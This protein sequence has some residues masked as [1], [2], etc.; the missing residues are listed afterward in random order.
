M[1]RSLRLIIVALCAM[2]AFA[3]APLLAQENDEKSAFIQYVEEQISSENFKISLNGI[4]GTLSSDVSLQSITIADRNGIW[5]TITK[6]R[7]IWSRTSLLVGKLDVE[8]LTAD[9]I[10]FARLPAPDNSAPTAEAEPFSLPQLPVSVLLEQIAIGSV[11][12][13][14]SVFGLASRVSVQ[15]RLALDEELLDVDLRVD[16]QD[17]PGGSLAVIANYDEGRQRLKLLADLQEPENGLFVNLLGIEGRPPVALRANGDGPIADF[18]MQLAFDV[19]QETILSGDLTLA[20]IAAGQQLKARLAGPLAKILPQQHRA[21]F[22]TNSQIGAT[23]VLQDDGIVDI[24][25]FAIKTGNLDLDGRAKLLSDGFLSALQLDLSLLPLQAEKVRLPLASGDTGGNETLMSTLQ[26]NID[27]DAERQGGWTASLAALGIERPDMEVENASLVASGVVAN[28]LDPTSRQISFTAR[29]QLN[30]VSFTDRQASTAFGDSA[31]FQSQGTWQS[32]QPLQLQQFEL[33]AKALNLATTGQ[34]KATTY[35]GTT[36]LNLLDL[37]AFS[38]LAGRE[39]K[40][41]ANLRIE[42]ST[43]FL[44]GAFDLALEGSA[45]ELQL[46]MPT[47]DKLLRSDLVLA[48]NVARN[49]NGI[50]FEA[51]RLGNRQFH[52]SIDGRYASNFSDLALQAKIHDLKAVSDQAGGPLN[53]DLTAN[54][55]GKAHKLLAQIGIESGVLQNRAVRRLVAQ[56]DGKIDDR[57]LSGRLSGSGR[58]DE[59][60]VILDGRMAVNLP[61]GNNALSF[62]VEE[63]IAE[64]G[65]TRINANLSRQG[66]KPIVGSAIITSSDISDIA[67]LA[68]QDASGQLNGKMD[69]IDTSGVQ[70]V[71]AN[72]TARKL[73][74]DY[75]S[76]QSLDLVG[77]AVDV[78]DRPRVGAT[79]NGRGIR[80]DAVE[81]PE[82]SA[83]IGTSGATSTYDLQATIAQFNTRIAANGTIVFEP[84]ATVIGIEALSAK[85]SLSDLRLRQ[86]TRISI[87][88][89]QTRI[90]PTSLALGRGS[91][92]LAG[93]Y[94]QRVALSVDLQSMPLSIINAVQRGAKASGTVSGRVEVKGS[95]SNPAVSYDL[96]GN[97]VST[98]QLASAGISALQLALSGS[99]QDQVVQLASLSA[100]NRQNINLN[101]SGRIPLSGNGLDVRAEGTAPLTLAQ[102]ALASRGARI[103]GRARFN[104]NVKG[105]LAAPQPTGLLTIENGSLNDPLSNLRLV[106]IGLL[107]GIDS[108]KISITRGSA[109]LSTGGKIGLTGTVGL[110]EGNPANLTMRL[111]QA[112]YTDG[113]TFSSQLDGALKLTGPL[114]YDPLLSGTLNLSKTEISVPESFASDVKILEVEHEQPSDSVAQTLQRLEQATP[115]ARPTSRPSVL[116]LDVTINAPNQIF[117][118][119]RGLDAELGGFIRVTGPVNN[120]SPVGSFELRRGRLT[121]LG[122]RLDLTEGE[123][124]LNGNLDP[125]LKLV[126]ETDAGDVVAYITISGPASDIKVTFTSNPELP[127]DEVLAQ[128]IFGRSIDDL[129]PSQVVKLA[130]IAAE[131]TGGSSPGLVDG[132]RRGTG[133]DD[134]D[135]VETGNGETAVKAGKYINDNVYLGVQAGRNSQEATIN[136]DITNDI[137]AKGS[138]D[139]GGASSIGIFLEKDY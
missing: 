16:R 7:L 8:S 112:R 20:T 59:R 70:T 65:A 87:A 23:A 137:K 14:E 80:T 77:S 58:L 64:I 133:L 99:F 83:K 75:F 6:P 73:K 41:R 100:S 117:I 42:G 116:R 48:G 105:S 56:F 57:L 49:Q 129:S 17:G 55:G 113:Q 121:I 119:G 19:Q 28:P 125:D 60:P 89:D 37:E 104:L 63:L 26:L 54:G 85:S 72:L 3:V 15:G 118:R 108:N 91:V 115:K 32:G 88:P 81:V 5:L 132:L 53:I 43:D 106:N 124:S 9:S 29:G 27:Y 78:F 67:A 109:S 74:S 21:F 86:P 36:R 107:A 44:I 138:V 102:S 96:K 131:L 128:I 135:V 76:A 103:G 12:I 66:D 22:G 39:M 123:V 46:G 2:M 25:S 114:L 90:S 134:L 4:E 13:D 51:F 45:S 68:L 130:S 93:T 71:S 35:R 33:V 127:E 38:G 69:F 139:S 24:S 62:A 95:G 10:D 34:F 11:S 61:S 1:G 30:G 82:I 101:A 84:A 122:Q 50:A 52:T 136:L 97:S 92:E 94:G 120:V 110:A 31:T 18:A 47:L 126:A 79:L 40:G 98:S 111:N